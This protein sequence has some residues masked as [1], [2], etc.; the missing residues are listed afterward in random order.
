MKRRLFGWAFNAKLAAL[1][2]GKPW[3]QVRWGLGEEKGRKTRQKRAEKGR[4]ESVRKE[5]WWCLGSVGGYANMR[6]LLLAPTS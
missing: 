5:H 2:A 1:K 4:K 3:S 6:V